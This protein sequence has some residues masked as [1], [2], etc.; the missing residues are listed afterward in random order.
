VC[1]CLPCVSA[2]CVCRGVCEG[3]VRRIGRRAVKVIGIVYYYYWYYV[4]T[5]S[6]TYIP[7]I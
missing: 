7:H 1:V 4:I 5:Y 2:V 3:R 6:D